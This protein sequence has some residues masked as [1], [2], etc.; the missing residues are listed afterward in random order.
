[1]IPAFTTMTNRPNI[2]LGNGFVA[3]PIYSIQRAANAPFTREERSRAA[4]LGT[5]WTPKGT[6]VEIPQRCP[7]VWTDNF[8][9]VYS[10]GMTEP[11]LLFGEWEKEAEVYGLKQRIHGMVLAGG[12]HYERMGRRQT[13][14]TPCWV[15]KFEAGDMSLREAADKE[16]TEEI[17]V[18]ISAVQETVLGGCMDYPLQDP[19]T[20]GV[21]FFFLR[22]VVQRPRATDELKR[23]IGVPVFSKL[24]DFCA[25]RLPVA[26]KDG[27]AQLVPELNHGEF[28]RLVMSMPVTRDFMAYIQSGGG[29]SPQAPTN[30]GATVY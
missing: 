10:E 8:C 1:M 3:V 16:L 30:W 17:G 18:P 20:H 25:G 22:W 13:D 12:G 24:S 6:Q 21:R 19:R 4:L 2:D 29:R 15:P 28:V 9:F 23:I 11:E 27:R 7:A 5:T 26:S 14:V